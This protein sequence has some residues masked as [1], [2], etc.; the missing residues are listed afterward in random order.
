[1]SFILICGILHAWINCYYVLVAVLHA[2]INCYYVLVAV[3]HAW[4]NCYY[5][6][7]AVLLAWINCYYVLV[8]VCCLLICHFPHR[9][10]ADPNVKLTNMY[11]PPNR[12]AIKWYIYIK[13][14]WIICRIE[15]NDKQPHS[16]G[17]KIHFSKAKGEVYR[18]HLKSLVTSLWL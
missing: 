14:L 13:L 4:I 18:V 1:M 11:K 15:I 8:A 3:L 10:G 7:V 6:L 5:V 17:R 16:K 9:P 2:W 12:Y